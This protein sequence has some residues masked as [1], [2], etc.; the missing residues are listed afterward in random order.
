MFDGEELRG[1]LRQAAWVAVN[2]YEWHMLRS[3]TG[4]VESEVASHVRALIVT[5]GAEG[6]I[7]YA[8]EDRFV[9]PPARVRAEVDPTGCGDAFRAGII[10]GLLHGLDWPTTGRVAS[11]LG[12]L[13]IE[14]RGTQNHRFTAGDI[15]TR[16]AESFG[17]SYVLAHA[18]E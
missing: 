1:F 4:F 7:I 15:A 8:G 13:K 3:R 11:L 5:R 12:A 16:Y 9:I 18:H 10:H 17:K 14:V 6:S 2:E